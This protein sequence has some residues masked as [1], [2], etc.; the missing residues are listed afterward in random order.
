MKRDEA[1]TTAQS[2]E[3][4]KYDIAYQDPNYRMSDT[5]RSMAVAT[6][7]ELPW[8]GSYLDVGCGRG[9]MLHAAE[10]LGFKSVAGTETV[11]DL[12]GGR[13]VHALG[14][15][16]PFD[17]DCFEVVSLFDV[18][19][20]IL[21]GDD[22]RTCHEIARVASQAVLIT[23]NNTSSAHKGI[24]LHVNRRPFKEW[25]A[26]FKSWFPGRVSWLKH[27]TAKKSQMWRI[28]LELPCLAPVAAG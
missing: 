21:P 7:C 20:H 19:E 24:E 23:A 8:R 13:I 22:E 25:D 26:L 27:R 16:L 5:R 3:I 15:A 9:E 14:W 10:R 12:I 17:D 2:I 11:S 6:L 4:A 1:I 18:I 28:D